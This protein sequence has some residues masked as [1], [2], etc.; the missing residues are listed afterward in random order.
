VHVP[1]EM[2]TAPPLTLPRL[3]A[4]QPVASP[5]SKVTG[6]FHAAGNDCGPKRACAVECDVAPLAHD[7]IAPSCVHTPGASVVGGGVDACFL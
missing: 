3:R 7:R 2:A 6:M 4:E 1:R 5:V